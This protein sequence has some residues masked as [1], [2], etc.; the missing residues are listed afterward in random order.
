M[1]RSQESWVRRAR[2]AIIGS[3]NIGTDLLFKILRSEHLECVLF[4]G[5]RAES[6]GLAIAAEQGVPTS[7]EGIDYVVNNLNSF[8]ILIDA[9]SSDCHREHWKHLQG[10]RKFVIDMTPSNIGGM[11]VPE[12]NIEEASNLENVNM[13]SCGGQASLPIANLVGKH[14]KKVD[15]LEVVSSIASNSAG[16]ATRINIDDYIETTQEALRRFSCI[17]NTKTILILNPADPCVDM[18]TTVFAK[19]E[20]NEDLEA[21]TSD[22]EGMVQ[23]MNQYIPGYEIVVPPTMDEGRLVVS[24]RVKGAGDYLPSYAGN[25]DIINCAAIKVAEEYA[26]G[27]FKTLPEMQGGM[28]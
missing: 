9:T 18:Q 26:Q 28:A 4:V 21:F 22:F 8:D 2:V 20:K 3:G 10:K 11:I 13:I 19:M 25:L 23:R 14:F 7:H 1:Q 15:Y 6:K 24:I 17:D 12:V 16:M 27:V 5:R